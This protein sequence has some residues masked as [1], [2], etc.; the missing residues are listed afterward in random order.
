ML[1]GW[2]KLGTL[3]NVHPFTFG[4]FKQTIQFYNKLM[5]KNVRQ[6]LGA[7]IQ[8][9]ILLNTSL[10]AWPLD[11]CSRKISLGLCFK[12]VAN[13]FSRS[14]SFGIQISSEYAAIRYPSTFDGQFCDLSNYLH[15][16][17]HFQSSVARWLDYFSNTW[18]ITA[19]KFFSIPKEVCQS[20]FKLC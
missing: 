1:R 12:S 8:T 17:L 14:L 7:G 9:H 2:L 20:R 10:L 13:V 6:V 18:Q 4:L 15:C 19:I 5:R 11:Q 3:K 16:P